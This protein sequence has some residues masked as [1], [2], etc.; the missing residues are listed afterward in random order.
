MMPP[1]F[2]ALSASAAVKAKIGTPPNM[3]LY[4]FGEA[5][6]NTTKPYVTWQLITGVP[7]NYLGQLPDAD[8]SRVQLNVWG[9]TQASANQTA[10]VVRDAIEPHAYVLNSGDTGRDPETKNYGYMLDV[11]FQ[12]SR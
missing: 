5:D 9:A 4:P 12:E 11:S 1:V 7:E 3:R 2:D 10:K 6:Q 8:S